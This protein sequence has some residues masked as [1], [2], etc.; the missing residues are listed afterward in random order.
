MN[1]EQF[2]ELRYII[3]LIDCERE[4]MGGG[5]DP[6]PTAIDNNYNSL[7]SVSSAQ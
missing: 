2:E 3:D 7:S 5:I 1:T 6:Y 4:L